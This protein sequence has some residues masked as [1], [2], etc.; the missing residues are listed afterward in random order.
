[1]SPGS[2]HADGH[3]PVLP[4]E[5]AGGVLGAVG[6]ARGGLGGDVQ[7]APHPAPGRASDPGRRSRRRRRRSSSGGEA[8]T[9]SR[10]DGPNRSSSLRPGRRLEAD[11]QPD[12]SRRQVGRRSLGVQRRAGHESRAPAPDG[13]AGAR[14]IRRRPARRRPAP[15]PTARPAR[16]PACSALRRRVVAADRAVVGVEHGERAVGQHGDAQWV[17]QPRGAGRAVDEAEV[18]QAP[19]RPPSRRCRRRRASAAP[20]TRSR[21]TTAG[22]R[23][24]PARTA[25]PATRPRPVRR[26][27]PRRWCRPG[28]R[29]GRRPGSP[30]AAGARRPRR[31]RGVRSAAHQTTSHGERTEGTGPVTVRVSARAAGRSSVVTAPSRS[32]TPRR[33]WLAVSATTRS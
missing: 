30:T 18:E 6:V 24:R 23:R 3:A 32:R 26:A 7:D 1:M 19:R 13:P 22:R 4:G 20:T 15:H 9:V 31:R 27:D 17:L 16:G 8:V 29:P 28:S 14:P 11:R 2:P 12:P 5:V 10:V 33:T 25:A 21:R